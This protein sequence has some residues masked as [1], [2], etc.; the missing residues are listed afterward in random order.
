MKVSKHGDHIQGGPRT[1][2]CEAA[3][4]ELDTG[5]MPEEVCRRYAGLYSNT[6]K[7]VRADF[8]Q[9]NRIIKEDE[10]RSCLTNLKYI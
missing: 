8:H 4:T 7:A 6:V 2:I 1:H 5:G 10:A 9:T 3:T